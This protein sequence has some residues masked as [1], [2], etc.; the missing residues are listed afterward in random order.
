MQMSSSTQFPPV[1]MMTREGLQTL[2]QR[3]AA[4]KQ[5][6][7]TPANN[8]E[9]MN[10][11]NYLAMVKRM[12][13][14]RSAQAQAQLAA[15]TPKP[16]LEIPTANGHSAPSPP[17]SPPT[18]ITFN[19]NQLNTLRSQISAWKYLQRGMPVPLDI[20]QAIHPAPASA[21][22]PS[23]QLIAP[24]GTLLENDTT[25]LI[26]PYNAYTHPTTRLATAKNARAI[27]PSITP[28]GLDPLA[29][30]RTRERF[31]DAR[32]A[33][34][35]RE[36]SALPSTTGEPDPDT[37]EDPEAA[38]TALVLHPSASTHGKL[39]ALIELKGLQLRARQQA[40]RR[41]VAQHLHEATVMTVDRSS[42]R[43]FRRPTLRDVRQTEL[44]E[45]Q[46]RKERERRAKQKHLDYLGT[47]VSHGREILATNQNAR[48]RMGKMGRAVLQFHVTAEKEEQKRIERISKERLKALKADD[49]EAYLKLIDTAKDTR[50][51]HLLKQT[52][53]YLDSLAQAVV[54]QQN[55]EIHRDAPVVA[56]ETEDGPASEAT[57][58]AARMDDPNE[59][60]GKVDY[61]AVAHRIS[62]KITAQPSILV[63]GKLKDYQLKGLQWMVSLYNNR[64]NGILA[65]EMGLGKTIQTISLVSFLIERKKLNGPYLVIVPLS[66]LTNWTLEFSKW[67]P[68]IVTVIYKGSPAVRRQLQLNLRAQS[69]QVLLT[70]FEYIIKDRPFLSKIK[71]V[72]MIIDEGHRMKNTQSRLSQTLNQFYSSRYRLILTGTPLQN[73]L[74]ELW[75]LLNFALPKIFNSVKSFDEWFNTPFANSGTADKIELNEEEA[76]L[77]IRRLHKVLRPFLLRRLKKDVESELP[78]K[79]EKV[80][81]CK[82]SAL[83]SQLYMQF[84]KH[85]MLFTDTRDAKGRQGG[86]KGLNNTVMQLRKICQHPFVFPEVEDTMNPSKEI[87]ASVYRASG[88]VALLD[89]I[90]PKL[91]A[92]K[93]RVLMFFQMTQVM[94]ILED[95]MY[96]RGYKF[97]RLDGGTKPDDRADL[98]KAFNAP[99][100]EYDVFLLSTRA[101]GLGLNLQTADTVIIYDSDWN[102]HADLQAQDRAHR[103]GQKNSVVI[104]RFITERSV[105]EHMLARAKQKLDMDGKVIQAGRFD[106]QSSAAE[107]EAVLR[108]MLEADNEEVN[109]DTVMDDDEINQI[110]ARSE[111]ELERFKSM[112]YERDMTEEREWR[113]AGNRGPKPERMI[114]F[115]ELPEVYQRDEPYE[116][117]ETEMKAIGRG[118]RERKMVSYNDGMTD[119]QWAMALEDGE[120]LDDFDDLPARRSRAAS[121]LGR[122]EASGSVTPAPE[123]R[124]K[125][126]KKGKGKARADD[127]PAGKRKRG[128][129]AQS[130]EPSSDE[131]DDDS[132][133]QKR[134]RTQNPSAGGPPVAPA[135]R[136]RMKAAFT[137]CH[138]A[139]QALTAEDGRQRCEL[140]KELPDRKLY[141]DYYELIQKPIAM[142]HMRKR[143]SSGYYKTVSAYR[144]DW[145]L[146][147]NNARS[148]NQEGSWV[149][150]DADAMQKVLEAVFTRET[151]GT[152]M[153][154]A[155]PINAGNTSP[156]S[157]ADD[158]EPLPRAPGYPKPIS[159]RASVSDEE[160]LS[161]NDDD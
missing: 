145:R 122:E 5:A 26:Y 6:G 107:S 94:N 95:Y 45:R 66:T 152:D 57:F 93:H 20:Q 161:S 143:M 18:P 69:F 118:A 128:G 101:G 160:Y 71:W 129:K 13:M 78:D 41:S 9:L 126:G 147:F 132:R 139:V 102:P 134:R 92:F 98:L 91:F 33:Q 133:G 121:R 96:H 8:S 25:S 32:I 34:R 84:K 156:L 150:E 50:I 17:N 117:P 11:S 82:M 28:L 7:F 36:L 140:F 125:R 104:L 68:S 52:D 12:Q 114:A 10:I 3:S 58:G 127:N 119:D 135:M 59:D 47:I 90:L 108:M 67:A 64:L 99:N 37:E 65:D 55:D 141:P 148:Y 89:R 60:R 146:M 15:P 130:P 159:R 24:S 97:M 4:L 86:I 100:S 72:H 44:L 27:V 110:I 103:I 73:N 116:P 40:L 1:N 158:D 70:T 54:A 83:Q 87:N 62:E 63:G 35:I 112:D 142:S 155:D 151:A 38:Q 123:E 74:P 61:Y 76:L 124:N 111:Q 14:A 42:I 137:A 113:E 16:A 106:N 56:F 2:I 109:E 49:E 21:E 136:D 120:D 115:Q 75:A 48:A 154:G 53:S 157:G 88:K 51:T 105:E 43:R 138:Q 30:Q 23:D 131:E 39:R 29:L 77:I 22:E 46:Q 19:Q 31:V 153:P 81:K 149:Y 85:G 79:I 144:D 80:I